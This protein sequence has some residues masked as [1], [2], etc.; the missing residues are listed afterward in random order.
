[1]VGWA[2][3]TWSLPGVVFAFWTA[4]NLVPRALAYHR[5]YREEFPDYPAGRKAVVPWVL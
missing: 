4:A 3:L 5:W 1:V 2:L